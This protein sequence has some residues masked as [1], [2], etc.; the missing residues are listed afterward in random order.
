M[1]GNGHR[2]SGERNGMYGKG[3]LREGEK[4]P[5]YGKGDRQVG[6]LNYMWGVT[7]KDHPM[8]GKAGFGGKTHREDTKLKQKE[9]ALKVAAN[10]SPCPHCGQVMTTTRLSI[11]IKAKHP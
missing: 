9:A 11:H 10:K 1:H 2:V 3:Y 6:S 8:Y 4:N 7:G 5:M